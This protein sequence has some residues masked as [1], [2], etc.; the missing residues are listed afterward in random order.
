MSEGKEME[1]D[2]WDSIIKERFIRNQISKERYEEHKRRSE[3]LRKVMLKL[4]NIW[5]DA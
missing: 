4:E 2:E 1:I 3:E 5:R